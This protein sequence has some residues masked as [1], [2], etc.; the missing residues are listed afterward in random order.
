MPV[1]NGEPYLHES[2]ESILTQTF[3][4]FE[5]IIINDGSTDN[6]WHVIKEYAAKDQ[7]VVPISQGNIGLT[8]SLN[9][10]IKIAKGKYIARQDADDISLSKRLEKQIPW[11]E[12]KGFDLCCSRTFLMKED[13]ISPR[14]SYFL[15]K[16]LIMCFYNPFIHGTYI[17]K[18]EMLLEIGCYDETFLYGQDYRLATQLYTKG[19]RIKYLRECLYKT[20]IT[21]FS[22]GQL[23]RKE[24]LECG[25]IIRKQWCMDLL[26]SPFLLLKILFKSFL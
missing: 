1:F 20:R 18:K 10:G 2:I 25:Q 4:D 24:Q 14:I 3:K 9:N 16:P 19:K 13:R 21:N 23:K 6:S 11:L 17:L 5:F 8:K 12:D 15:P 22:I 7:R 26:S